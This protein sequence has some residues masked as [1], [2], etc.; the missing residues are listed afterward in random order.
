MAWHPG[1]WQRAGGTAGIRLC[2][3]VLAGMDP[4]GWKLSERSRAQTAGE[5][6]AAFVIPALG[7][8]QLSLG[9]VLPPLPALPLPARPRPPSCLPSGAHRFLTPFH[10][11]QTRRGRAA[12]SPGSYRR[13]SA[14]IAEATLLYP[15]RKFDPD[16]AQPEAASTKSSPFCLPKLPF[17]ALTAPDLS[18]PDSSLSRCPLFISQRREQGSIAGDCGSGLS[19]R[20]P[21]SPL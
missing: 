5:Y 7:C 3:T 1:S 8:L 11:A 14:R 6:L 21:S 17:T 20:H 2:R 12:A 9:A 13:A 10:G 16:P 15:R 18:A 19:P 4:P